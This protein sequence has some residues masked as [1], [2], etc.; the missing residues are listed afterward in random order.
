MRAND[1]ILS[2][3]FSY[4]QILNL[5]SGLSFVA[6]FYLILLLKIPMTG[7]FGITAAFFCILRLTSLY[8]LVKPN[9][10]VTILFAI[11][12]LF[13]IGACSLIN[14]LPTNIEA[15]FGIALFT[16]WMIFFGIVFLFFA[17]VALL[18]QIYKRKSDDFD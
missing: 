17:L 8:R 14:S 4:L 15:M 1:R 16:A 6:C 7:Y 2:Q 18:F 13:F 9:L 5:A 11:G 10:I 12:N 3:I